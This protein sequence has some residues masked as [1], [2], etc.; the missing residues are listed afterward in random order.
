[1]KTLFDFMRE[2]K[3]YEFDDA[4]FQGGHTNRLIW[5]S[6]KL[7]FHVG[8]T[9]KMYQIKREDDLIDIYE[10]DTN[11]EVRI[12]NVCGSP[13]QSGYTCDGGVFYAC[14]DECFKKDMDAQ[15][16]EGNWRA[17]ETGKENELGGYYEYLEENG[18]WQPEPSYYTEW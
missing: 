3:T 9:N 15:Y 11:L 10:T 4:V 7:F 17:N 18:T 12:C 2:K 5:E 16:G 14:S 8:K 6:G 1:M 13:M